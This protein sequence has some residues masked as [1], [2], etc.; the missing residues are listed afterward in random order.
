MSGLHIGK[1]RPKRSP[2]EID[3][4]IK[5]KAVLID[6]LLSYE[7]SL[8][9]YSE[10]FRAVLSERFFTFHEYT[11]LFDNS[12]E[13]EAMI[14]FPAY[15]F[16]EVGSHNPK[17]NGVTA[18]TDITTYY[19]NDWDGYMLLLRKKGLPNNFIYPSVIDIHFPLHALRKH[20]YIRGRNGSGKSTVIQN[21][22]IQLFEDKDPQTSIIVIDPHGKLVRELYKSKSLFKF[23]NNLIYIDLTLSYDHSPCLNPFD[24]E[25]KHLSEVSVNADK[26]LKSFKGM[27]GEDNT[28][29]VMDGYLGFCLEPL[30]YNKETSLL[31]LRIILSAILKKIRDKKNYKFSLEEKRLLELCKAYPNIEVQKFFEEGYLI[32]ESKSI[33]ALI[34]RLD[35]A[36]RH[37]MVRYFVSGE[38]TFD[39]KSAVNTGKIILF[40]LDYNL[41]GHDGAEAIS[42]L[43]VSRIQNIAASRSGMAESEMPETIMVI[44]EAQ[45]IAYDGVD[46]ALSE[47]RKLN[48]SLF[49]SHQY[50]EQMDSKIL[51][52]IMSNCRNKIAGANSAT[53]H[54]QMAQDL[55]VDHQEM[56]KTPRFSFWMKN[57]DSPP[58]FFKSSQEYLYSE[59][60]KH[61]IDEEESRSLDQ[62]MIDKYYK[63]IE[64]FDVKTSSEM[65]EEFDLDEDDL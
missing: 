64:S 12:I 43:L 15:A 51:K 34:R 8:N 11:E 27:M 47:F 61:Y 22:L 40:N 58:V 56:I 60:S 2:Q 38:S 4:M 3:L 14:S 5:E 53:D 17:Y 48:F 33:A 26:F 9:G 6:E 65:H 28:S 10:K 55:Q 29:T 31:D 21:I 25:F 1:S 54:K 63:P 19:S 35:K 18:R 59:T 52:S 36:L 42:R 23:S 32:S 30:L 41:I 62:L 7:K 16:L 50:A 49:L 24:I 57:E 20:S 44:D 39:L 13:E 45:K 46:D 37:Q